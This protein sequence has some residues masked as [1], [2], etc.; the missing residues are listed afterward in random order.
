MHLQIVA[1]ERDALFSLF[2]RVL[3]DGE[4]NPAADRDKLPEALRDAERFGLG[5]GR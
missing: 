5:D 4:R 1:R 3:E 2:Q